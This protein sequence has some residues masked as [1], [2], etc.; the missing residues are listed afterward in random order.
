MPI[1]PPLKI[2]ALSLTLS[3]LFFY[4]L[5]SGLVDFQSAPDGGGGLMALFF[6]KSFQTVCLALFMH[7]QMF[8]FF[9]VVSEYRYRKSKISPM[10]LAREFFSLLICC[11]FVGG[12]IY[13]GVSGVS[14]D[15]LW[16]ARVS[17]FQDFVYLACGTV[18]LG[19][20]IWAVM[21]AGLQK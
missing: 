20:Y 19:V 6:I 5:L 1:K 14:G 9:W 12:T 21:T 7:L 2:M 17:C 4:D 13:V 11:A 10:I 16:I 8:I 15:T 18:M 3:P